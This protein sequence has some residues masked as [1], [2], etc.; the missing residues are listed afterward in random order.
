MVVHRKVL[1]TEKLKLKNH[2]FSLKDR[3]Y[4]K[5]HEDRTDRCTQ[6]RHGEK[7]EK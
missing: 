6:E 5:N 7:W 4:K 1:Q 2:V 3:S